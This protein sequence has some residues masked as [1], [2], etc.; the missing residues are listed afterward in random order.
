VRPDVVALLTVL[1]L[2]LTGVLTPREALAGFGDPVIMVIAGL[3]VVGEALTRTGV[4]QAISRWIM[5]FAGSNETRILILLM[6]SAGLLGAV[7]SSTAVVAIFIPVALANG[8]KSGVAPSRLLIPLSYASLISGMLTLT[9]TTPNL[10]ASSELEKA[11]FEQFNFFDFTPV[12][13]TVLVL[14]IAYIAL[15]GRRFLPGQERTP[16]ETV[17]Q[18]MR[19]LL[20]EFDIPGKAD[21]L[22][23]SPL[24]P[25]VGR[26]LV[27]SEIGARCDTWVVLLEREERLGRVTKASP[28]GDLTLRVGD[29]LV[30]GGGEETINRLVD[31]NELKRLPLEDRHRRRWLKDVGLALVLVHPESRMLGKSLKGGKF[32]SRYSLNVLAVRRKGKLMERFLD[33][34]LQVGDELLVLGSWDLIGRLQRFGHDFVL[35]ALPAELL[36][37]APARRLAP[38]ALLILIGMALLTALEIVPIVVAVLLAALAV[39]AT[40]TLTMEDAYRSIHLSSLVLVAGMLPVADALQKTG[41]VDLVVGG[42]VSGLGDSGPHLMLSALFWMTAGLGVFPS[43]TAT[44]VLMAPI[45]IGAAQAMG[46]SPYAFVMTIAIAASAVFMSPFS[47]PVVT[48]VVAPGGYRFSDFLKVGTPL[49]I[50]TWHVALLLIPLLF[51]S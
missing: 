22:R 11:G 45:A 35:L 8:R 18:G 37:M 49:V 26:T 27:E 32:R 48:L 10:V 31:E 1:A 28:S 20:A 7:M 2:M 6:A 46:A 29:V 4:A 42:L 39:V 38:V 16:V 30:L 47:T 33:K 12:G 17:R 5:R 51:P 15:F 23:I 34:S 13:L 3:L 19:E 41:G 25:L 44:A 50:L 43:N 36:E 14:G 40:R 9:A 24:S 21:R